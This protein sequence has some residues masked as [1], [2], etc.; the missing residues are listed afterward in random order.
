MKLSLIDIPDLTLTTVANVYEG[1]WQ[2]VKGDPAKFPTA[3]VISKA[4]AASL[5]HTM[6]LWKTFRGIEIEVK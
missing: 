1:W 2:A 4:Q 6:G 3:I 5:P